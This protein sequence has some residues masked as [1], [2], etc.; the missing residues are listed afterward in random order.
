MRQDAF[1]GLADR[2]AS[3]LGGGEVLLCNLGGEDSEFA[4]LN[5]NRLRQGGS[6]AQRRLDLTLIEGQ[7][8][9][10]GR[11]DLAGEPDR[12]LSLARALLGRLRNH[13]R[14]V[15]QDPHLNYCTE[16]AESER[17][18][19]GEIPDSS[20]ALEELL[21]AAEGLDLVGIWA[22]GWVYAGFASSLGHRHWHQSASFNL[23]WSCY[24]RGDKAV[25]ANYSGFD[26]EP[27]RLGDKLHTA[28]TALEIMGRP[29]RTIAPGRYRA[30]LAPAA[31][32]ELMDMLAWGGFGLKDHRTAQTPL[33]SL[34][35]GE[36]SLN[37]GV[38]IHEE[39][40]RGLAPGFT[41]EGF[42]KPDRV[43]LVSGGS[44]RDCLVDSR[45]AK[46]YGAA[47]NAG[48]EYP[49]SLALDAGGV[50]TGEVL[51]RLG[52]GLY[53]GNLWYLN[54]ADR[55]DCRITGMTRFATF[56]VENG[57]IVAPVD[58]MRFDDSLYHLLGERLEGLTAEQEL[59]LSPETYEGRS[60]ASSLLPGMLVSGIE[61][62]L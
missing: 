20:I 42:I 60:T 58:V 18:V 39:H 36:R 17:T 8:Q 21:G 1:F 16:P 53:I 9:V 46:E 55:N 48:A 34:A 27:A 7:R 5:A 62:A 59:I 12:D 30:Y 29:P 50:P 51:A 32:Q 6:V 28:R 26:W 45:S 4:R 3:H 40:A 24:L 25:K 35:R 31:V 2:L 57:D 15:P 54:Y 47:V 38:A 22:S 13:L 52:T 61:L 33:L 10:E 41:P 19:G 23:D 11:C 49:E 37:P 43:T 56:W 14:Q 44:Y